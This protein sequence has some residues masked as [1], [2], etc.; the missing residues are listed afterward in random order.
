MATGVAHRLAR[1]HFKICMTEIEQPLAVRREVSFSEAIYDGEKEVEGLVSRC[2]DSVDRIF[3]AWE[4]GM[5]PILVDSEAS[6]KTVLKPDVLVD[7]TLSKKNIG[8]YRSDAPLVIGLGPGFR[9][10]EDVHM[11][12]ETNRGHHLGRLIQEGC[13]EP[14]T[15]VPGLIGGY[16]LQRVLKAPLTGKVFYSRKIG[17]VLKAGDTVL[18]VDGAPVQTQIQG[19]LRGL[20]RA[21]IYVHQGIK[22]GDIDPR[23]TKE[24]C[25]TISEKARAIAGG[26][27]EGILMAFNR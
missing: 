26:V 25:Y 8:T 13:A 1:A 21:G 10:G 7:A 20:I 14:D 3:L 18:Y 23:G 27:L 19:T 15:G 11:V 12:V 5:I 17:E 16:A 22:V 24:H 4:H 6:I 9:A 2:V